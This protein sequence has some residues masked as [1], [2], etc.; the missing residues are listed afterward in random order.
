MVLR[1]IELASTRFSSHLLDLLDLLQHAHEH[2]EVLFSVFIDVGAWVSVYVA[3]N[4]NRNA[5]Y[6]FSR[7]PHY[8]FHRFRCLFDA[9][10]AVL[11]QERIMDNGANRDPASKALI[12][13]IRMTSAPAL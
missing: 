3:L 9:A 8:F 6:V 1:R 4:R 12:V 7:P 5:G 2:V 13:A 11:D 10:V